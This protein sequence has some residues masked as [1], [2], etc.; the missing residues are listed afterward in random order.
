VTPFLAR[1]PAALAFIA[2]VLMSMSWTLG[3]TGSLAA[4]R[5]AGLLV[6]STLALAWL[7]REAKLDMLA[8]ALSLGGAA[9]LDGAAHGRARRR[10]VLWAGL[11]L[12]LGLLTKGPLVLLVPLAVLLVGGEPGSRLRDRLRR[13]PLGRTCGL[14]VL[15]ALAWFVPALLQ[16]G[17]AYGE[18]LLLG[19]AATRI[20][21]AGNHLQPPWFYL[22]D[23]PV[24]ALPWGPLYLVILGMAFVP[25]WSAKLGPTAGLARAAVVLIVLYSFVPTKHIR[26]LAP[27]LPLLAIPLAAWI[28]TC[29]VPR[30]SAL[31]R[32]CSLLPLVLGLAAA[33]LIVACV[34]SPVGGWAAAIPAA[35]LVLTGVWGCRRRQ[36]PGTPTYVVLLV[37]VFAI[38]ALTVLRYRFRTP[39]H[40]RFNRQLAAT[41]QARDA[42]VWIAAPWHPEDVFLG[43][44]HA[45]R[46]ESWEMAGGLPRHAVVVLAA[47]DLPRLEAARGA[48]ATILFTEERPDGRLVVDVDSS[49]ANR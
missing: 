47:R 22:L 14:A 42:R 1:L 27:V 10:H 41:L 38:S 35:G 36:L 40:V 39:R 2:L 8:A 34:L 48:G 25:R 18:A 43:A 16:A 30:V 21:G 23:L 19:Q 33:G 7:G 17:P 37:A 49:L 32:M 24:W 12:G 5:I 13:A 29:V 15:V 45:E 9:L 26:Y 31:P 46:L 20:A 28:R 3:R 4:A 11:V 44:P 6:L